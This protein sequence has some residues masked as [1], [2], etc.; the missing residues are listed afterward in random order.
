MGR[1]IAPHVTVTNVDRGNV[2]IGDHNQVHHV[3][4]STLSA[5]DQE[6]RAALVELSALL[7]KVVDARDAPRV[8]SAVEDAVREIESK[9]PRKDVVK[10][11]VERALSIA[12]AAKAIGE[13]VAQLKPALERVQDW[14]GQGFGSLLR[15][16]G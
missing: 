1:K 4:T 7:Q 3:T 14:L 15:F 6:V 9:E 11:A 12:T 16:L 13:A 10:D 8:K 2:V 5:S